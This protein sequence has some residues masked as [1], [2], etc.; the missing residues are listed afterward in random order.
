LT[1][2][3]LV[4]ERRLRPG[5]WR[6]ESGLLPDLASSLWGTGLVASVAVLAQWNWS[7]G[8]LALSTLPAA[9]LLLVYA[10]L[11]P[12]DGGPRLL[13]SVPDIE[14]AIVSLG[15]RIV[16]ILAMALGIQAFVF[17][18]HSMDIGILAFSLGLAKA[19]SWYFTIR[20][21]CNPP[22]FSTGRFAHSTSGTSDFVV[23]RPG[24]RDVRPRCQP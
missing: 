21:V 6:P 16:I 22:P 4:A 24:N 10:A 12:R 2:L 14:E 13:P 15:A 20:T 7:F 11:V 23:Y 3:L 1:P 5:T 17:G 19:L 8:E 18:V 9:M